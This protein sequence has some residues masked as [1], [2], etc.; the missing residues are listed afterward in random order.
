LGLGWVFVDR[1]GRLG[2]G[3]A[4]AKIGV[5]WFTFPLISPDLPDLSVC[6]EPISVMS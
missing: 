3:L 5:G 6:A 2:A 4:G 1:G